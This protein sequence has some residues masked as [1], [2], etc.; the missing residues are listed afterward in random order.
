M[1]LVRSCTGVADH[2]VFVF[3]VMQAPPAIEPCN[4]EVSEYKLR[5]SK[6]SLGEAKWH[7]LVY[8]NPKP[9]IC[10]SWLGVWFFMIRWWSVVKLGLAVCFFRLVVGVCLVVAVTQSTTCFFIHSHW[11]T[12]E[13]PEGI[14]S[15]LSFLFRLS[16]NS[17]SS[18][19]R[20][21]PAGWLTVDMTALLHI[22]IT[23]LGSN[24][25]PGLLSKV[26]YINNMME[27]VLPKTKCACDVT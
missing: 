24:K 22:A 18:S 8:R 15:S 4:M 10:Q 25:S 12:Y 6:L 2:R 21:F 27:T 16:G 7:R 26:P 13:K 1:C 5:L 14:N 20:Y 23:W 9:K 19:K 11:W 3:N 17:R